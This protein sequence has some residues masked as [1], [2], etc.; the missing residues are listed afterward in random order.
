MKEMN[1]SKGNQRNEEEKDTF[2][3]SITHTLSSIIEQN[4]KKKRNNNKFKANS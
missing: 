2:E 4:K 1:I 3:E